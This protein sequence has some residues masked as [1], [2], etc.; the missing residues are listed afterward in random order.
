MD[1]ESKFHLIHCQLGL[2][3][4]QIKRVRGSDPHTPVLSLSS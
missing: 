3:D 2:I 1:N 4:Q